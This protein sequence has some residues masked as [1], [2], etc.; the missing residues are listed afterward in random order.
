MIFYDNVNFLHI[1]VFFVLVLEKQC[2]C[3][4][5]FIILVSHELTSGKLISLNVAYKMIWWKYIFFYFMFYSYSMLG[6]TFC[7]NKKK[8]NTFFKINTHN[9]RYQVGVFT[10]NLVT[11]F[12]Q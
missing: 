10:Y 11:K 6:L 12:L 3:V 8:W 7:W 1:C 4:L 5:Y 9:Y 2:Q